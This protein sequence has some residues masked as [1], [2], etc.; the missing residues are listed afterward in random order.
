MVFVAVQMFW[1]GIHY[2]SPAFAAEM[3]RKELEEEKKMELWKLLVAPATWKAFIRETIIIGR[4][5][6]VWSICYIL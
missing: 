6:L 1:G 3:R 2:N 4:S 5:G